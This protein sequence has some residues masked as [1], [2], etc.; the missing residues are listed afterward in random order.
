[1][2]K[3]NRPFSFW[4]PYPHQR[5]GPTQPNDPPCLCFPEPSWL[6]RNLLWVFL[7]AVGLLALLRAMGVLPPAN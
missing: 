7:A 4:C 2:A 3:N 5:G 6:E 1:M